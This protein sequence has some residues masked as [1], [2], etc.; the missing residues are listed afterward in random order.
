MTGTYLITAYDDVGDNTG[1]YTLFVQR[2]NNP[3]NTT[4]LT[5]G[6]QVLGN[7]TNGAML[8]TYTFSGTSGDQILI[9][10][11][12]AAFVS[13]LRLYAPNGTLL[14]QAAEGLFSDINVT[15]PASGTYVLM[16]SD[17]NGWSTGAYTLNL[18]IPGYP[19]ANF[20]VTPSAR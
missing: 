7:I 18:L 15:L 3:A 14:Q 12:N 16:A 20:T 2:P 8:D 17:V 1:D 19:V 6:E 10:M 5:Y 13:Q 4:A 11:N 9:Q